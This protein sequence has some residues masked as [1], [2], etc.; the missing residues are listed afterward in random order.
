MADTAAHT[1]ILHLV[2]A[3]YLME[4]YVTLT[5]LEISVL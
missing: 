3:I 5:V 4:H 2:H 1:R